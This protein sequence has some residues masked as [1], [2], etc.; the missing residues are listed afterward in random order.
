MKKIIS[1][2]VIFLMLFCA[3]PQCQAQTKLGHYLNP[4]LDI[5]EVRAS[6]ILVRKRK[7]AVAIKKDIESGKIT[8]EEGLRNSIRFARQDQEAEIWATLTAEKW[9]K[10]L[11]IRRLICL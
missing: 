3:V 8:F 2:F 11:P 10:P 9:T 1:I 7:D 6:H 4:N 5:T